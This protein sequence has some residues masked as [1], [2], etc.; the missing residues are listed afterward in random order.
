MAN[1]NFS[2][3]LR[4]PSQLV[5]QNVPHLSNTNINT[6]HFTSLPNQNISS[7]PVAILWDMENCPIPNDICPD[8]V[9]G[10]IRMA[11]RVHPVITGPVSV[12]SAYGDFN[13]VPRKVRGSCQRTGVKLV[14]IPNGKKDAAD[15]AILVDMFL[16]ALDN[17]PPSS[18]VLIS[19]DVDFSP[20]LHILGQ[21]GYTVVLVF[22]FGK[23]VSSAL[24]N[25]GCFVWDW[26][27]VARGEVP[28]FPP[29]VCQSDDDEAILYRGI[30]RSSHNSRSFSLPSGLNEITS[31][32][33]SDVLWARPGDISGLKAQLV[34]LLESC[35][36]CL[37]LSRI[38]A[39]YQRMYKRPLTV[40]EYGAPKL[41]SLMKK[42]DDVL[43]IDGQGM[44]KIVHIRNS[45][46]GPVLPP[47]ILSK[48][49]KKGKKPQDLITGV[50]VI[51]PG[52]S[53]EESSEEEIDGRDLAQFKCELQEILVSYSCRIF[54]GSFEA[55]YKQR[56]KRVLD[57]QRFGVKELEELL[58]KVRDVVVLKEEDGSER[59]FLLAAGG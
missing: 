23:Y 21:R 7:G 36:G 12:F 34:K 25:A 58:E 11:L 52:I 46:P 47:M 2:S 51:S 10:N 5:E 48:T 16:F 39:E 32:E 30:V 19:G 22:P 54:L 38:P 18:I 37:S 45:K 44:N 6:P 40:E 35:G 41:I 43:A 1:P 27:S 56:Y 31:S 20:A 57:Y 24:C 33:E 42:V 49:D 29:S 9:A 28:F 50:N 4:S 15:K 14:D 3:A 8:G 53:S 13:L 17:P 59:K 26:H 55:I